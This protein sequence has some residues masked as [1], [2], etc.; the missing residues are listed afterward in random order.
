MYSMI[1]YPK[2]YA[3][4]VLYKARQDSNMRPRER[5]R[6]SMIYWVNDI[7]SNFIIRPPQKRNVGL[8]KD[9]QTVIL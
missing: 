9:S 6:E 7:A 5:V 3:E 8:A 2:V 4:I 1:V